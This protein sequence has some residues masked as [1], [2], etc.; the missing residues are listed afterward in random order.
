MD[1]SPFDSSPASYFMKY[2]DNE[3]LVSNSSLMVFIAHFIPQN[4]DFV[5]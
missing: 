5:G 4:N 1:L 3:Q 2:P